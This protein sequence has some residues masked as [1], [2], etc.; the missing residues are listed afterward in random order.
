[1]LDHEDPAFARI[2]GT[3]TEE[4]A[5]EQQTAAAPPTTVSIEMTTE[6]AKAALEAL[7]NQNGAVADPF[8]EA[9]EKARKAAASE[10]ANS[11]AAAAAARG[12]QLALA[13]L[14]KKRKKKPRPKP[15]EQ[16]PDDDGVPET[17]VD[18]AS[19]SQELAVQETMKKSARRRKSSRRQSTDAPAPSAETLAKEAH[20]NTNNNTDEK[21]KKARRRKSKDP[22]GTLVESGGRA[23]PSNHH[24][25]KQ[26]RKKKRAPP[27]P[28]PPENPTVVP[29][30]EEPTTTLLVDD[31]LSK[32]EKRKKS[33]E[34]LQKLKEKLTQVLEKK[35]AE[36]AGAPAVLLHPIPETDEAPVVQPATTKS[37]EIGDIFGIE[38]NNA[39][40]EAT[41]I[42]AQNKKDNSANQIPAQ[43]DHSFSTINLDE[44]NH[45]NNKREAPVDLLSLPIGAA[46]AEQRPPEMDALLQPHPTNNGGLDGGPME[47]EELVQRYHEAEKAR[48]R[49]VKL[50]KMVIIALGFLFAVGLLGLVF[51][52]AFGWLKSSD[53][54]NNNAAPV[55]TTTAT[56]GDIFLPP[57]ALVEGTEAALAQP[58]SPQFRAYDWLEQ[59]PR[60][61]EYEEWQLIQRFAVAT[62]Y[63]AMRKTSGPTSEEEDTWLRH[64]Q[65]ECD[66]GGPSNDLNPPRCDDNGRIQNLELSAVSGVQDDLVTSIPREITL[67]DQ[68]Q[69]LGMARNG[70]FST[71]VDLMPSEMQ[72]IAST[73][74]MLSVAQNE[75]HTLIQPDSLLFKLSNLQEL[76]ASTNLLTGSIP[77]EFDTLLELRRLDLSQNSLSGGIPTLRDLSKL[78]YLSLSGNKIDGQIPPYIGLMF[79]LKWLDLGDT[80]VTGSLPTHLGQSSSLV[81]L[82]LSK[83]LLSGRI[84]SEIGTLGSTLRVLDLSEN[85][86]EGP[87]PSEIGQ[88]SSLRRLSLSLSGLSGSIPSQVGGLASAEELLLSN[89]L[90][91]GSLPTQLGSMTNLKRLEIA[92]N[93]HTGTICSEVGLLGNNLERLD[94]S[95]NGFNG[96]PT[97]VG[98]L[99]KLTFLDLSFNS[100][101]GRVPLELDH[102]SSA[103]I[104]D[105]SGN[106]MTGQLPSFQDAAAVRVLRLGGNYYTGSTLPTQLGLLTQLV[107]L[108]LSETAITGTI[109]SEY[110]SL[111]NL[112]VLKLGGEVSGSIPKAICGPQLGTLSVNCEKVECGKCNCDCQG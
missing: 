111:T 23:T 59:D 33:K 108:D 41:R 109:P 107:E 47:P 69:R 96:L 83:T 31:G 58:A 82:D 95:K 64:D 4:G 75:I 94:L 44:T 80:S 79:S 46:P 34:E 26:R 8:A 53:D 71:W 49:K 66:W 5:A 89:T 38:N 68:I 51:M 98:L 36:E 29:P 21:Q 78:E 70:V 100:M 35:E 77:S 86:I 18:E 102:L 88:L 15:G 3:T 55:G 81:S 17:F 67:L 16:Q 87:L 57:A 50:M 32:K 65:S 30:P 19:K 52:F 97:E 11:N 61:G 24:P 40:F 45:K 84:P 104:I 62:V 37:N 27:P 43:S 6:E 73:F 54:N 112:E 92:G 25:D 101:T 56:L 9:E 10:E 60:R 2:F 110:S 99:S 12:R 90:L 28:P 7:E 48:N 63:F 20:D 106:F 91:A 22:S 14:K 74:R 72:R 42:A 105:I 85:G 93:S 1:M 39:L 103:Q 76:D 13:G